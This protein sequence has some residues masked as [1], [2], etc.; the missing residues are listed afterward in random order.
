[1]RMRAYREPSFFSS[2]YR[3]QFTARVRDE[4]KRK[5]GSS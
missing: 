4:W 2:A 1:M 5:N 3:S